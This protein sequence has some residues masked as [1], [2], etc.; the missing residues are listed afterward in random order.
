MILIGYETTPHRFGFE[1]LSK[2]GLYTSERFP[3]AFFVMMS[4]MAIFS[5]NMEQNPF[6]RLELSLREE[7]SDECHPEGE[8]I[9]VSEGLKGSQLL[10]SSLHYGSNV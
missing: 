2:S 8:G 4:V 9:A 7:E 3:F 6:A 1:Q 5:P 10:S